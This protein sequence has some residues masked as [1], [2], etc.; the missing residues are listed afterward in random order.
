MQ[1]WDMTQKICLTCKGHLYTE[2]IANTDLEQNLEPK[3]CYFFKNEA[4]A[5]AGCEMQWGG[6]K[7]EGTQDLLVCLIC[8]R[9]YTHFNSFRD[10]MEMTYG[11]ET[12]L[13]K[14]NQNPKS[15]RGAHLP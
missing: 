1:N 12:V 3:R 2:S 11:K 13:L 4:A 5:A 8:A 10:E 14:E 15:R 9:S 6:S 7:S